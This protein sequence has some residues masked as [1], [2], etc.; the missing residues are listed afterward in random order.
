MSRATSWDI[1]GLINNKDQLQKVQQRWKTQSQDRLILQNLCSCGELD[2]EVPRIENT[3]TTILNTYCKI[4]WVTSH[5]KR[6]WNSEVAKAGKIWAREK[7]TL[8]Q[9]SLDRE[10]LKKAQNAFYRLIPKAKR[11]CWQSFLEEEEK[12]LDSDQIRAE[13]KN[14]C[15]IALKYTKTKGNSITSML[16]GPNNEIAIKMQAKEE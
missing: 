12:S 7:K 10:K 14:R 5:S 3:L 1:Q 11:E 9:I 8:A 15:W 6:W 13:D 16:I 2:Q 4:M